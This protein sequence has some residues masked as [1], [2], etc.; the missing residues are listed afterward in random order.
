MDGQEGPEIRE[1]LQEKVPR[2]C[3]VVGWLVG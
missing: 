2:V 3:E 1:K